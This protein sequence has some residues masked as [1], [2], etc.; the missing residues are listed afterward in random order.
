[1]G[2][3]LP[4]DT[5]EDWPDIA[6]VER[7]KRGVRERLDL[8]LQDRTVSQFSG[9]VHPDETLLHVALIEHRLM[10]A[11]DA[12]LFAPQPAPR[13]KDFATCSHSRFKI[14]TRAEASNDSRGKLAYSRTNTPP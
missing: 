9:A 11:E 3:G 10:H 2:G 8:H 12:G 14:F 4:S 6:M 7:Y 5:P 1:M 13:K